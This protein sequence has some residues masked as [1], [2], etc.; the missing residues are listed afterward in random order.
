MPPRFANVIPKSFVSGKYSLIFRLAEKMMGHGFKKSMPS[1]IKNKN[2]ARR[3]LV[4]AK[5]IIKGEV[6][7]S[8]NLTVKRPGT[9][10]SP[11]LYWE[12]LGNK[13]N[14]NYQADDLICDN[15]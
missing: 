15:N 14:N 10:I 7:T 4:A 1:E 6:F 13:S 11:M 5:K 9:G 12:Y 8:D 2:I 3:S